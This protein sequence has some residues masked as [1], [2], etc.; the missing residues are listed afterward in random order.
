MIGHVRHQDCHGRAGRD[1]ER[2]HDG[3]N[4]GQQNAQNRDDVADSGN[5]G[6]GRHRR[7]PEN[8]Q[9]NGREDR[10]EQRREEL[11]ADVGMDHV[12]N[13]VHRD[14]QLLAIGARYEGEDPSVEASAVQE[15]VEREDEDDDCQHEA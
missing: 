1:R 13:L 8:G 6:Q 7:N 3:R 11:A 4:G 9:E 15:Q 2:Q 12:G 10:K 14:G 5:H